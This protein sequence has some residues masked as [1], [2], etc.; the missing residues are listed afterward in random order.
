MANQLQAYKQDRRW[1]KNRKLKLA[2]A[3]KKNPGNAA[4]IN[5]AVIVYRRKTPSVRMWSS[6]KRD[7]ARLFKKV[8]GRFDTAVFSNNE[9]TA[10]AALE[11]L[12]FK[13]K[14]KVVKFAN[15]STMFANES[16]MFSIGERVIGSI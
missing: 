10:S 3:L 11:A 9:K 7:T 5:S 13:V 6:T 12:T 8:I 16:T 4:Q 1:E 14:P 15:G 2:R